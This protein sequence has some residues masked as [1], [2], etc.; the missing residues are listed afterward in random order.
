[1]A[2]ELYVND[3]GTTLASAITS[4]SA[5]SLSVASSGG[6][7]S[8]G[9]FRILIDTELI[10]V[11]SVS[12]TTWTIVRGI[13]G[14]TAATH[15]GGAAVNAI[16]T[17]GAWDAIRSNQSSFGPYSS[18]PTTGKAGDRYKQ[19]DGPYE[20]IYS[21]SSWQAFWNGYSVTLPPSSGWTSEGIASQSGSAAGT[22]HYTNGYGYLVGNGLGNE[23]VGVQYM[24]APSTP[25]SLTARMMADTSG[26][27][28]QIQ[29]GLSPL[30]GPI[31]LAG[32]GLG[33]RDSGGKYLHFGFCP[34]Q[35]TPSQFLV[36]GYYTASTTLS[37]NVFLTNNNTYGM[38]LQG[39]LVNNKDVALKIRNDGTNLQFL[40]SADGG[41]TFGQVYSEAITAHLSDAANVHWGAH[42]DQGS[43]TVM[44]YDWTQGT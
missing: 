27:L 29:F 3:P 42:K 14:T 18:L 4:T 15:S 5:T 31:Q 6:Y 21:G 26:I 19:T 11:T 9:N 8:S 24:A 34:Q 13:E 33:F 23:S 28:S 35:G 39:P 22:V 36:I 10:Q 12:G 38:V 25:Y 43:A 40:L 37:S 7:P 17:A 16:I 32:Y 41:Q 44:L 2:E 20:W 30:A 1:M